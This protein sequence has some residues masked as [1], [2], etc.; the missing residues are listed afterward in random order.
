MYCKKS[1]EGYIFLSQFD[2]GQVDLKDPTDAKSIQEFISGNRLALV[3]EFTQETAPKIF[4]GD[5]KSHVLL[6]LSKKAD[7]F[8]EKVDVFKAVAAGFKGKVS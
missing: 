2:E 1:L 4:G 3:T 7:A 8:Q 6:F 5:I